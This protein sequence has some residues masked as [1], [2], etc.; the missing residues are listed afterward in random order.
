M[1][2]TPRT[3]LARISGWP[4]ERVVVVLIGLLWL[5]LVFP[6][7]RSL[8]GS[9]M[10]VAVLLLT[11]DLV[12][13]ILTRGLAFAPTWRLDERLTVIRDQA[14]RSA[15]RI[16]RTAVV[17][18]L[19]LGVVDSALKSFS[20]QNGPDG[21][22]LRFLLA[23]IEMLVVLPTAVV[24]WEQT[25]TR[26]SVE[27]GPLPPTAWIILLLAPVL[28][29]A[30][31]A[32]APSLPVRYVVTRPTGIS[33]DLTGARCTQFLVAKEVGAGLAGAVGFHAEVCWNGEK[34]FVVGDPSLP[35]PSGVLPQQD[36]MPPGGLSEPELTA[37]APGVR[38]TD[39][40][41]VSQTCTQMIDAGGTL[42]LIAH[43]RVSPYP[44]GIAARPL[45]IRL[46]VARDGTL[47]A[48]E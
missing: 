40:G 33:F 24:A 35:L 5:L 27:H 30:W 36:L 2:A 46:V 38:E 12:L 28:L 29:V 9:G 17:V 8:G 22:S 18:M 47:V 19:V 25:A 13:G 45:D 48:V 43:G 1:T 7:P 26:P 31:T 15:F 21:V 39:F 32:L 44:G 14:Y 20:G 4:T 6:L 37:C 34:A 3:Q 42:T 10:L 23:F 16:M 41:A 11:L